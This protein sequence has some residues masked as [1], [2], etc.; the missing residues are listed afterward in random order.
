MLQ[1]FEKNIARCCLITLKADYTKSNLCFANQMSGMTITG[2][3]DARQRRRE[4]LV[5]GLCLNETFPTT[6]DFTQP[7]MLY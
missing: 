4:G 6:V 3:I 2:R 5:H 7:D 1:A